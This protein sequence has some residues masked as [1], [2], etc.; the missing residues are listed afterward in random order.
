[1][2]GTAKQILATKEPRRRGL[3]PEDQA[4]LDA[5]YSNRQ[6]PR[7]GQLAGGDREYRP[8][9]REGLPLRRG[10]GCADQRNLLD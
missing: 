4:K 10:G 8:A 3:L 6:V 1:M 2:T 5:R 7:F 9:L